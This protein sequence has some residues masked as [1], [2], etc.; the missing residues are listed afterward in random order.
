MRERTGRA[1]YRQVE[2]RA[3]L[4]L[5]ELE[6]IN[7]V[8]LPQMALSSSKARVPKALDDDR[9]RQLKTASG[10]FGVSL[11]GSPAQLALITRDQSRMTGAEN[12]KKAP[13]GAV[14]EVV[15]ISAQ[16]SL[17]N[18]PPLPNCLGAKTEVT[19]VVVIVVIVVVCNEAGGPSRQPCNVDL[20]SN[21]MFTNKSRGITRYDN[22]AAV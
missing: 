14:Q 22:L 8:V 12:W 16:P 15:R 9:I 21:R 10:A 17:S 3:W 13:R 7:D 19:V 4:S 11:C 1:T 20:E 2:S 5:L 18:F 6:Q